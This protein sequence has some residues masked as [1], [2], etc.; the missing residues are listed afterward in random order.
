MSE[1]IADALGIPVEE[2]AYGIRKLIDTRMR[3][4]IHGLVVARGFDLS[5]YHLLSFGGG[6]PG[7]VE[8]YTD[9]IRMR[10]ILM[11]PYS[12][13]FSAFG[14]SS[15][16]YE[17]TYSHSVN[18]RIPPD[19]DED[20]K[21]EIGARVTEVWRELQE[22]AVCD[23][24]VEGFAAEQLELRRMAMLRYGRQLN[25]LIVTSPVDSIEEPRDWDSLIEAFEALYERVYSSAAKYPQAGFDLFEVALVA[26][27]PKIRPNLRK[28][29]L[30]GD[31]P[32]DGAKLASRRAYFEHEWT[33]T[34]VWNL[35]ALRP[36][37]VVHG[38]SIVEDPTTTIVVPP[39]RRVWMDEY[40]TIWM[41]TDGG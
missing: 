29:A 20:L 15:A 37:N 19:A 22:Q 1:R 41:N 9:G 16:D 2:A 31:T 34:A 32:T 14:A 30:E 25:D 4:S 24:E 10:G 17:H 26:R 28:H 7:H 33:D 21:R 5:E 3:E 12:S 11:F 13:V 6:G 38:P 23:M 35:V 40:R 36:G 18:L 39:G 27:A 8:G